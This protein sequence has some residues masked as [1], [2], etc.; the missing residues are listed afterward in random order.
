[1][2][3]L[4]FILA[5]LLLRFGVVQHIENP[6]IPEG[7]ILALDMALPLIAGIL[8]GPRFGLLVGL[9][10]TST[11]WLVS[12]PL[13]LPFDRSLTL[14][15]ILPLGIAGYLSGVLAQKQSV[16]I[17]SLPMALPMA[18]AHLLNVLVFYL[19]GVRPSSELFTSPVALW[20]LGET[21]I[22]ILFIN[23]VC[24][25]YRW[26]TSPERTPI[27]WRKDFGQFSYIPSAIIISV[28]TLTSLITIQGFSHQTTNHLF[29]N[30]LA[31][32][33]AT[34]FYGR[35]MGLG[36]S[37]L[38]SAQ[39]VAII[40]N[41]RNYSY[42]PYV[43]ESVQTTF[44]HVALFGITVLLVSELIERRGKEEKKASRFSLLYRL[45]Q[46]FS[47]TL[48]LK[49]LLD[50]VTREVARAMDC[51]KCAV[52]LLDGKEEISFAAAYGF[53]AEN[54]SSLKFKLGE[55]YVGKVA[56]TGQ[57]VIV[58]DA[59]ND[60]AV[61]SE[62]VRREHISSFIHVPIKV[63]DKTIGTINVNNKQNGNFSSRDVE[64]LTVLANQTAVALEN[65][66]LYSKAQDLA[67]L[68]ERSRL[69]R[70][71]HDSV[72]QLLFSL[73]LNS[74]VA[75]RQLEQDPSKAKTQLLRVHQIAK[76]ARQDLHSLIFELRPFTDETR[77]WEDGLKNYVEG[78]EA[79]NRGGIKVKFKV[80]D[81]QEL[82]SLV[83]ET[84]YRVAQEALNNVAKHSQARL[85]TVK[86]RKVPGEVELEVRDN[87]V[88]FKPA[89][90]KGLGLTSMKERVEKAGGSLRICSQP[91]MGTVIT[92]RLP[93]KEERAKFADREVVNTVA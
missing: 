5:Y 43:S 66:Q 36:V 13:E 72:S 4:I 91:G 29:L 62:I 49:R 78:I 15:S 44:L 89:P 33:F 41:L 30:Y 35:S 39:G 74:E 87:G 12:L 64:L 1:M 46:S 68:E 63:K 37:L 22:G 53:A 2:R 32:F 90:S 14:C 28:L 57:P 11:I 73:I 67:I 21:M 54:T 47:S 31:I 23:L 38:S 70:E 80:E 20:L 92:A 93:V 16:F 60:P 79:F 71:L 27:H 17:S 34:V 50:V 19:T 6:M 59:Q 77:G 52:T 25:T 18:L 55:G 51:E 75:T 24:L 81:I 48:D 26:W 45:S 40:F 85:A 65:A 56:Q 69:A 42:L 61:T 8:F 10:G 9:V 7:G 86:V 76:Q 84:L 58:S 3:L 88:G 82:P 83:Q